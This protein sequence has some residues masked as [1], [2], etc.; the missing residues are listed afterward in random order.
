MPVRYVD[1]HLLRENKP[2]ELFQKEK[3]LGRQ[4]ISRQFRMQFSY[5]NEEYAFK[6]NLYAIYDL[7]D[8]FHYYYVLSI[9]NSAL[10]SF[11]QVNFNT[12]GQRDDFPSF[13]LSDFKNF[14]I[15]KINKKRQSAFIDLVSQIIESKTSDSDAD[16]A[17]LEKEIDQMV[18]KLYGL[19]KE[20]IAIVE[21]GV[22]TWY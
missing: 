14:L 8:N 6:K 12:S 18:Y 13:S 1:Y 20:E 7:N 16:T 11:V 19:T 10:Y 4:L 3:I 9:L 5:F 21:Q 22:W 15:P 2:I 17:A